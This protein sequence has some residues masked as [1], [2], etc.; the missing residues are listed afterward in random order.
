MAIRP[1][2]E[3]RGFGADRER[4]REVSNESGR[5]ARSSN[6]D[7]TSSSCPTATGGVFTFVTVI[8]T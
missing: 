4:Q 1:N 6:A 7:A 3:E 8:V 2:G 5:S